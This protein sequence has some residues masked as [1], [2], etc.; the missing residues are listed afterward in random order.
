M[1]ALE[2]LMDF[3][4]VSGKVA[5]Y[6]KKIPANVDLARVV[7]AWEMG[8]LFDFGWKEENS[9]PV[10]ARHWLNVVAHQ[11]AVGVVAHTFAVRINELMPIDV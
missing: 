8:G 3:H 10:L 11:A 1:K 9:T 2:C 5:E 6:L 7:K 4:V